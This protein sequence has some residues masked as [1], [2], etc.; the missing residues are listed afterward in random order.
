MLGNATLFVCLLTITPIGSASAQSSGYIYWVETT[1]IR[2][3]DFDGTGA[4]NVIDVV[5]GIVSGSGIALD[6]TNNHIYWTDNY[7]GPSFRISRA[8]L[9]GSNHTSPFTKR[10]YGQ[11]TCGLRH[12]AG[13]DQQLYLLPLWRSHYDLACQS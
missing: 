9:D 6:L 12:R 5:T 13:S 11:Y 8:N 10:P 1:K 3:A 7:L 2:R 4:R